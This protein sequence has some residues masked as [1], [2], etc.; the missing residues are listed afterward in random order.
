MKFTNTCISFPLVNS[1]VLIGTKMMF[2]MNESS[3][4]VQ[5]KCSLSNNVLLS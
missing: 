4:T 1:I 3:R 5:M 2:P